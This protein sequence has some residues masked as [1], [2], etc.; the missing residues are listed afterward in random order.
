MPYI[1]NKSTSRQLYH[2][3]KAATESCSLKQVFLKN[4]LK[5]NWKFVRFSVKLN[6]VRLSLELLNSFNDILEDFVNIKSY[7]FLCFYSSGTASCEEHIL[8]AASD[9]WNYLMNHSRFRLTNPTNPKKH[10]TN[11]WKC[12]VSIVEMLLCQFK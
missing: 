10:M 1:F 5:I 11:E 3:S 7:F 4:T 2:L 8:V 9:L 12:A 6:G